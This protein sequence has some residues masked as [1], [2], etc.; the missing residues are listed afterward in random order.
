MSLNSLLH[1]KPQL[2]KTNRLWAMFNIQ[3]FLIKPSIRRNP[4]K[5]M[6]IYVREF[7]ELIN[8]NANIQEKYE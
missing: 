2:R 5:L 3:V 4:P 7:V 1:P 8:T 6:S